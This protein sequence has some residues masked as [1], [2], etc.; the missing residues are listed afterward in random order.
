MKMRGISTLAEAAMT[1]T[2]RENIR[3]LE[4]TTL[5]L[6]GQVLAL[7]LLASAIPKGLQRNMKK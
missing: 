7:K 2:S 3:S 4:I 6:S 5:T 1:Q